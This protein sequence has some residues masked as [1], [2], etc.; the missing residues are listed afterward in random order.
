MG[1]DVAALII[2]AMAG[3][4]LAAVIGW[5][6]AGRALARSRAEDAGERAGLKAQ[7]EQALAERLRLTEEQDSL[8]K[9]L[10]ETGE[11]AARMESLL[12]KEREATAEKLA[13]I[14]QA[15]AQLVDSFRA[16]AATVLGQNSETF[17]TLARTSFEK[18]HEGA[19]TDL[20]KR[21]AAISELVKPVAETLEKL[22]RT[23]IATKASLE[24]LMRGVVD[25]SMRVS[26]KAEELARA[27]RTPAVRGVYG[28]VQLKRAVELAGMT[29]YCDFDEQASLDGEDGRQRP[30]LIVRLPGGKNVVVDA[31][32]PMT[33][34]LEYI[35]AADESVRKDRQAEHARQLR[36]HVRQL[37]AKSYPDK[38][39][40]ALDFVVLFLPG[41]V[42]LDS[43]LEIDPGLIEAGWLK[44]VIVVTPSSIIGLLRAIHL[45]WGE[46]RLAENAQAI[47]ELGRELYKRL[48]DMGGHLGG[49]GKSLGQAIESYNSAVG[50]L[51]SRVLSQARRFRDLG[52]TDDKT[53]FDELTPVLQTPRQ[54][55][56]PE[57]TEPSEEPARVMERFATRAILAEE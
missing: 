5:L 37:A 33:A 55:Q 12:G 6:L 44:R 30:D 24:E 22:D 13:L 54:L 36:E 18:H 8:R 27:L 1:L 41:E 43:A 48:A 26:A 40:P 25:S 38:V 4:V 2:G 46:Q 56:K 45:G 49:L 51:E 7:V 23:G 34:F 53:A 16:A 20:D 14:D 57:L 29:N 3:G 19:R 42:L 39:Q 21:Q 10:R 9:D 32:A 17:L 52:A 47:K 31:K 50:S 15:K 11:R 35:N 28:Q